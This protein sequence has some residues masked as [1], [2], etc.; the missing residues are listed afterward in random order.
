MSSPVRCLPDVDHPRHIQ[1]GWWCCYEIEQS[2][3]FNKADDATLTRTFGTATNRKIYTLSVWEKN[4]NSAGSLLE[5]NA[6][7]GVTWANITFG[8]DG[9]IDFFDYS[10]GAA[11]ID[12]RTS[13]IYRDP[14]AWYHVVVAVD[15]TQATSTDRIKMY[16]NGV[17]ITSFGTSTYPSLNFEGFIN[18]AVSHL[19]G[20]GVNGPFDGYLAEYHFVDGQALAPTDFGEYNNAG[21]WIPIEASPTYGNNGF[22]I[23]GETASDL[24]ED[25]SGNNNDFTSSGL[26]TTDQMLDTPTDNFCTLNA[27]D[28]ATQVVLADGNLQYG[29]SSNSYTAVRGTFGVSS[30]KWYWEMS[31]V[32]G[33][34]V[35]TCYMGIANSAAVLQTSGPPPDGTVYGYISYTGNKFNTSSISYGDTWNTNGRV[36][37]IALDLDAGK[38]WWSRDGVWQAS[39]DPA[40][41]TN[42]A[43]SGITGTWHPYVIFNDTSPNF[44]FNFG[45]SAFTYTPPT[46]FN[47]LNTANLPTPSITDGSAHFQPT[48][49]TGTGSSL[50]VT[51]SGNST[52][53]PDW[54]WIK[55]RSGATEHVLTDAV[56]GVT[57]ELSSNDAGA[58]ETVAQGL[59]TFG[60]AGFTVGTDG[61]YNTSSATY[62]GWQWKA[63]G[64]GSSNTDG[65]VASTVSANPTAGFSIAKWTHT[66][67][68]NYTVGHGLGA[69]PKMILVK[70]TDQGTNWGVYHSDITVGN[71]LILNST[72]AQVAGY[73]GANSWTSSTFSIGSV[74]DTNG[75]TAVAYC[76]AEI[77]GYSSIGSYEGNTNTDGPFVYTG[78]RPAFVLVKNI[79]AATVW[80]IQDTAR[81]P[82]NLANAQVFA[83]LSIAET[84]GYQI[85]ILSNGFKAR[86]ADTGINGATMIYMAFAEHPFGGDGVAPATAR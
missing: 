46:G 50:A 72:S 54:V 84:T 4:G 66:T 69:V 68:S 62:V 28:K 58:E 13:A 18:S 86:S 77:P 52:F 55:G 60:S 43:F 57:K 5:Y 76:F 31:T 45:Q 19:I 47:T 40:A 85:D 70:T 82:F 22:Y 7:G 71:R 44:L 42:E 73:W 2:I 6:T 83:N 21:V 33:M 65:T 3:R 23:T 74:R 14:S 35:N 36:I 79:D 11:R 67:A 29:L 78:F 41:G 63:N 1:G 53:Q 80:P 81:S 24:G 61:S 9:R 10:G 37:G 27:V 34:A 30:G 64:A 48:L 38:I 12:L 59:T 16:V 17:Q 25:F 56:R 15:T 51:Q 32:S 20:D 8:Q 26:A 39:G 49:Y 75:S